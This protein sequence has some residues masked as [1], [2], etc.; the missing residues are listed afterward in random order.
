MTLAGKWS[1]DLISGVQL[2]SLCSSCFLCA[3]CYSEPFPSSGQ[4]LR[5]DCWKARGL[6]PV[7]SRLVCGDCFAPPATISLPSPLFVR[8]VACISETAVTSTGLFLKNK[9]GWGIYS[10]CPGDTNTNALSHALTH[11]Q[12]FLWPKQLLFVVK[13]LIR[14]ET[15]LCWRSQI[16]R[17]GQQ[18]LFSDK[19]ACFSVQALFSI[20]AFHQKASVEWLCLIY[21]IVKLCSTKEE[22]HF[23]YSNLWIFIH[24]DYVKRTKW[25][26]K[27]LKLRGQFAWFAICVT[28]Q[29]F[30]WQFQRY[31]RRL[32]L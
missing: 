15:P 7:P 18:Q 10:S 9:R 12:W 13:R 23:F 17:K 30:I 8:L 25:L 21:N 22:R 20:S 16:L 14:K 24:A 27:K 29:K 4:T 32:M 31:T 11:L 6:P 1:A 19:S 28:A 26:T 3:A 5:D 2:S